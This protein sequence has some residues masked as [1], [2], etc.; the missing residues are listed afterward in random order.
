MQTLLHASIVQ[1]AIFRVTG[2]IKFE[3]YVKQGLHWTDEKI[4]K[5]F[6]V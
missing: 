2:K 1:Q 6:L 4:T 3:S 5:Q